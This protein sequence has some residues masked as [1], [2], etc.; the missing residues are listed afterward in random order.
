MTI[1]ND[2]KNLQGSFLEHSDMLD[3]QWAKLKEKKDVVLV[4]SSPSA[5]A[6]AF[7]VWPKIKDN[8]QLIIYVGGTF[9]NGD[10]TAYAEK[11]IYQDPLGMESLLNSGVPIVFVTL[12]VAAKRGLSPQALAMAYEKEWTLADL[13]HCGV[14]V[15]IQRASRCFG[16][17]IPDNNAD[18]KYP[19]KN[20]YIFK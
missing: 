1:I 2:L 5:C 9:T 12:E 20:A 17:L 7:K 4:L 13:I 18:K 11:S 8:I 19:I 16:K 14:H 6:L 15:E 3:E 10:A